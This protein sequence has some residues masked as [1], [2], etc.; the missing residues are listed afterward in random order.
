MVICLGFNL[1]EG[2]GLGPYIQSGQIQGRQQLTPPKVARPGYFCSKSETYDNDD[3][4]AVKTG[5]H[6]LF[7][8]NFF[9][10]CLLP[11]FENGNLSS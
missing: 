10:F 4:Q 9:C 3:M 6:F 1:S 2:K 8:H 7:L 5:G 11:Q